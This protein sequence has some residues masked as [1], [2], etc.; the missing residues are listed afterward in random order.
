[1]TTV[2]IPSKDPTLPSKAGDV[3][4]SAD[5]PSLPGADFLPDAE[6]TTD[7][8]SGELIQSVGDAIE[9]MDQVQPSPT[10]APLQYNRENLP[11]TGKASELPGAFFFV[12]L[13]YFNNVIQQVVAYDP[14]VKSGHTRAE[15][16][17]FYKKDIKNYPYYEVFN[18][19]AKGS[20]G[21]QQNYYGKY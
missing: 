11:A 18:N 7:T 4:D 13:T 8:T 14:Y 15:I 9:P 16:L 17:A 20:W 2:S 21:R 5:G 6:S 1:M 10:P 12:T 3:I 19:A